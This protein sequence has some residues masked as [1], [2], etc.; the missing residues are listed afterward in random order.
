MWASNIGVEGLLA[1]V[2]HLGG[3]EGDVNNG[4]DLAVVVIVVSLHS[5]GL[6][7][8]HIQAVNQLTGVTELS[9]ILTTHTRSV[10]VTTDSV[11]V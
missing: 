7:A 3:G 1:H 9:L 2:G 5:G 10:P 11:P 8:A 4:V 6:V